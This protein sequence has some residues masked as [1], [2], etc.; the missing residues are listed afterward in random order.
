MKKKLFQKVLALLLSVTTLFG[1]FVFSVSAASDEKV[2]GSNQDT[3]ATLEE[4]QQLVGVLP[5]AEYPQA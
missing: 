2:Y 1:V 3:A 4:M 5:Y